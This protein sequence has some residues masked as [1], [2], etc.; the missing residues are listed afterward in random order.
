MNDDQYQSELD[1]ISGSLAQIK[2]DA[3]EQRSRILAYGSALAAHRLLLEECSLELQQIQAVS[4]HQQVYLEETKSLL[5]EVR[6]SL[7][8]SKDA[9]QEL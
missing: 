9:P 7:Q 3:L 8:E 4:G 2:A 1:A 6:S 5:A